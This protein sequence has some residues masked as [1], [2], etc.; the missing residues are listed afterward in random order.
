MECIYRTALRVECDNNPCL[1]LV[2][3]VRSITHDISQGAFD[4]SDAQ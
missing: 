1:M 2:S 3:L 4:I